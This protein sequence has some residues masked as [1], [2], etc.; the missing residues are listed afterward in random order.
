MLWPR[1]FWSRPRRWPGWAGPATAPSTPRLPSGCKRLTSVIYWD[2]WVDEADLVNVV[3]GDG[4]KVTYLAPSHYR[5]EQPGGDVVIVDTKA[6]KAIRLLPAAKEAL[7]MSGPASL[8]MPFAEGAVGSLQ[9]VDAIQKHFQPGRKP[10]TG[11]EALGERKIA[12]IEAVG[13]RSTIAGETMEA[14]IN[15]ATG[16]PVEICIRQT[17]PIRP[18]DATNPTVR[19]WRILS[20]FQYDPKIDP[21]LMSVNA[22]AGYAAVEMPEVPLTGSA[23]PPSL[24]DLADLLAW[25]ARHNDSTFPVSLSLDGTPGT[26]L[27]IMKQSWSTEEKLVQSG[28]DAEKQAVMKQAVEVGATMGR[29]TAFLVSASAREQGAVRRPGREA[30]RGEP[31]DFLVLAQGRH[32]LPGRLRGS[33]DPGGRR[34]RIAGAARRGATQARWAARYPHDVAAGG[35]APIG[36]QELRRASARSPAGETSRRSLPRF[37]VSVPIHPDCF[38][39]GRAAGSAAPCGG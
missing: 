16:L 3:P 39:S 38:R 25:C 31:T 37:E 18:L 34:V 6:Q 5:I 27:A 8:L 35:L 24:A 21:A 1:R 17:I 12:K 22:P 4:R 9:M 15:S 28:S 7:V 2:Q 23:V 30:R 13:F 33:I 14:W 19:M 10:P 32:A 26:C 29:A 11:V 36:D 20:G